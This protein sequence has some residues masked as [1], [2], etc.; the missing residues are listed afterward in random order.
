MFKDYCRTIEENHQLRDTGNQLAT[1][2]ADIEELEQA[3]SKAIESEAMSMSKL[4][5]MA[6][7]T[8]MLE[9]QLAL[10]TDEH[11]KL[12]ESNNELIKSIIVCQNEI[13]KYEF[14]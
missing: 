7:H 13:C 9:E 5:V 3:K 2:S 11:T 10:L 1:L 14:E 12:K 8:K 4:E 6:N